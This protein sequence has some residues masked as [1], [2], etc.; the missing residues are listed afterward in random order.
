MSRKNEATREAILAYIIQYKRLHDGTSPSI[1]EI[2][3]A[4][5]IAS[6]S[7]VKYHLDELERTGRITTEFAISRS[8]RVPGGE[9]IY[10]GQP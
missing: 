2:G 8:I 9:W 6:K 4:C 7:T 10:R 3:D 5:K 1:R